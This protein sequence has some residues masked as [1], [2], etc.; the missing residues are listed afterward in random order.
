MYRK[1]VTDSLKFATDGSRQYYVKRY[2]DIL[3][4]EPED[5]RTGEEI[6][7]DVIDRAGLTIVEESD[8]ECIRP[9]REDNA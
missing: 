2:I 9:C 6:A 4:P 7:M 3:Y 5:P 1:Y 8:N